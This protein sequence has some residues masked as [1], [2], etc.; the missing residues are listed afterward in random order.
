MSSH[1]RPALR[2]DARAN[3]G[4][5]IAAAHALFAAT[6][7]VPLYEVARH[8][9]VGQGTLYRHF[10][11]REALLAAMV[12]EDLDAIEVLLRD[13]SEFDSAF[14]SLM[15]ALVR[16]VAEHQT[17]SLTALGRDTERGRAAFREPRL[18]ATSLL[19]RVI[20]L[21]RSQ[22]AI[23]PAVTVDDIF[24][25]LEMA[26]AGARH[27]ATTDPPERPI[28][29]VLEILLEGLLIRQTTN[30]IESVRTS[31]NTGAQPG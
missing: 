14:P 18:R 19:R 21:G 1:S 15:A 16:L 26:A 31:R 6:Q 5:I 17:F 27:S 4:R 10:P 25:T 13:S 22:A 30:A 24:L 3:R 8:A 7:D 11:D 2:A 23:G 28:E 29:R 9:G 20:D 12:D